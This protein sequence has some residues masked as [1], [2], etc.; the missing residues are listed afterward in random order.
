MIF[1][2]YYAKNRVKVSCAISS[3]PTGAR[4]NEITKGDRDIFLQLMDDLK[5]DLINNLEI[6][7]QK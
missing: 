2:K 3:H 7:Y 6:L 5:H 4:F 1:L